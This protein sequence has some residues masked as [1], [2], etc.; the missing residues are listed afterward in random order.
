MQ[1]GIGL[2]MKDFYFRMLT[3][4]RY[5]VGI[6]SK[7]ADFAKEMGGSKIFVIAD[8]ILLET[9][10]LQGVF[11]SF[12][13]AGMEYELFTDIVPEPPVKVV[14]EVSSVMRRV[15]CNL[16][17][18]IGGGSTIDTAKAVCMLQTHEG[19]VKDYLFGGTKT[20]HETLRPVDLH[21]DDGRDWRR[22]DGSLCHR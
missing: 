1:K 19:S 8:K 2:K 14:D 17:V 7:I 5:G 3:R 22:G 9:D 21:S 13:K 15:G 20:R 6:S 4:V 12:E 18:A 16:C 10:T 11:E